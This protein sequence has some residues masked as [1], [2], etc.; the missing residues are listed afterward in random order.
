[1]GA[2]LAMPAAGITLSGLS[3][4]ARAAKLR[5]EWKTSIK[6]GL[7]WIVRSQSSLGHWTAGTYPTAMTAL[8]GTALICSGSTTTQGPYARAI[9][10][11]VDYITTKCRSNGLIG[12]P[13]SDNR[14][15]YGHGFSMLF[16]SQVLGEEEDLERREELIEILKKAAEFSANAQTPSGGWGYVS[17][18]DGNNFDEGSTTITQVQG[19][20]G[21]VTLVSRFPNKS[22][23]R[24]KIISTAV[25]ILMVESP[26][27]RVIAGL[28]DRP[29]LPHHWPAFT[30][31]VI[32]IVST[33]RKCS[34][35]QR[36]IYTIFPEAP[37]PLDTGITPIFITLR[38]CTDRDRK[39]GRRFVINCMGGLPM[40]KQ[41]MEVGPAT[42]VPFM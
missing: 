26:I 7:D 4:Q 3:P 19:L 31:Q 10:K 39:S 15:T 40:S 29:L 32:M 11:S 1:M 24:P 20:R 16:L 34:L 33:C 37:D 36:K 27:A 6:K 14:Y 21:C 28:R 8:A 35:T 18:K 23:I 9:R 13:L 17:A 5:P 30:M 2:A 38:L 12:D 22:L 41:T 42:L 25:R